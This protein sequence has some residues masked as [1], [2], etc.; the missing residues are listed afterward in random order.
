MKIRYVLALALFV[1]A[2]MVPTFKSYADDIH[3]FIQQLQ[4][5]ES[6]RQQVAVKLGLN[7]YIIS[8]PTAQSYYDDL[9]DHYEQVF[10]MQDAIGEGL[11]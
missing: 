5:L 4:S 7:D 8:Y 11:S 3:Q 10:L 6:A 1:S 2:V 9:E